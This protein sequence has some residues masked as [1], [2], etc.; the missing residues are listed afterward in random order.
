MLTI[1]DHPHVIE[2]YRLIGK[3][4]REHVYTETIDDQGFVLVHDNEKRGRWLAKYARCCA[5]EY[6]AR[7]RVGPSAWFIHVYRSI[8]NDREHIVS[9]RLQW[10]GRSRD[11]RGCGT[12]FQ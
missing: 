2:Y 8:G 4:C 9:I 10:P 3:D 11:R 1:R 6:L 7:K 12:R 5:E